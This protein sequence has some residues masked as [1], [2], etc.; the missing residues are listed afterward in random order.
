LNAVVREIEEEPTAGRGDESA[1]IPLCDEVL[2]QICQRHWRWRRRGR[3]DC[4]PGLDSI[5]GRTLASALARPAVGAHVDQLS[6]SLAQG[7]RRGPQLLPG[8]PDGPVAVAAHVNGPAAR[9]GD[10][11]PKHQGDQGG[12]HAEAGDAAPEL[13]GHEGGD[14]GV[15]DVL[16]VVLGVEDGEHDDGDDVGEQLAE[17]LHEEDGGEHAGAL[18]GGGPLGGDDGRERALGADADAHDEA[19]EERPRQKVHG[20]AA[21]GDEHAVAALGE[22]QRG[23]GDDD[24]LEAVEALAAEAVGEQAEAD[25]AD[26]AADQG[27]DVDERL[28]VGVGPRRPVYEGQGGEDDICRASLQ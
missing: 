16:Q 15:L 23:H 18:V 10:G 11:E 26:D 20:G 28:I 5:H 24:E 1:P 14:V 22:A 21:A 27:E 3:L 13:V 9:L 12:Q 4:I 25:L 6:A 2:A 19:P 7:F 8:L 17:R